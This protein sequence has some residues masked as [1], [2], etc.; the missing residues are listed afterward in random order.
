LPELLGGINWVTSEVFT[1]T[2]KIAQNLD[3]NIAYLPTLADIDLPEDLLG[4][5][6]NI[7]K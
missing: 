6:I 4:L 1:A 5:D 3:L 7:L 2:R